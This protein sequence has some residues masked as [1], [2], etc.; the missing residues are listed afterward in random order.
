MRCSKP[1]DHGEKEY[2]MDCRK[3]SH[4]YECGFAA[5][6][7]RGE[8]QESLMRFK[9]GGRQEYGYFYAKV[10]AEA[11]GTFLEK[12]CPDVLLPVPIH[13]L[14]FLKRG[15]NQAEILADQ[16]SKLWKL[17]VNTTCLKRI[18]H[19][20]AQKNLSPRER[21]KNLRAAFQICEAVTW[22]SVM[23]VD[24]IY[25]TGSTVDAIAELLKEAGVERVYFV[26]VCI[27]MGES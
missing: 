8:M 22:K 26:T 11:A 2:C 7:Y 20:K 10:L 21:R 17:P 12:A 13:R 6:L 24:D 27:G 18:R 3:H 25:T 5:F 23:L 14:K 19:T 4:A 1:L 9:Y 16:L 15:Y